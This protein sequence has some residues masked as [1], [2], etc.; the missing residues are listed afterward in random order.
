M[1]RR[2]LLRLTGSDLGRIVVDVIA[3]NSEASEA[4]LVDRVVSQLARLNVTS[5]YWP[6]DE[7]IRQT[8]ATESAYI[9]ASSADGFG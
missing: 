3:A 8:L 4:E 6:G 5:T 1:V 2:Q 7:E 9:R